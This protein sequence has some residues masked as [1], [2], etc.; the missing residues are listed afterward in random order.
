MAIAVRDKGVG[1]QG[2]GPLRFYHEDVSDLLDS[3]DT[4][5]D[6]SHGTAYNFDHKPCDPT[7]A[8]CDALF[9]CLPLCRSAT[10]TRSLSLQTRSS[11]S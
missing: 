9:A 6:T 1:P 10:R 3:S 2:Y 4:K 7:V 5:P 11:G 8:A